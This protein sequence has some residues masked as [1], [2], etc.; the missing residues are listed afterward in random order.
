MTNVLALMTAWQFFVADVV[1]LRNYSPAD[2]GRL[3]EGQS[4]GAGLRLAVD[5]WAL[6]AKTHMAGLSA[7]MFF[8]VEHFVA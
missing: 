2:D 1:A 3:E 8:A 4:A 5:D 7:L 6:L